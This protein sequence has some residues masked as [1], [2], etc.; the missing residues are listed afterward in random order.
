MKI[1]GFQKLSLIDYPGIIC[2]IVFTQGCLFRCPYCHNSELVDVKKEGV[3]SEDEVLDFLC[4]KKEFVEGVSITGG[5]PTLQKDLPEF[6]KKIKSLGF[7]V[8]LDTSG[9]Y[10]GMVQKLL[11]DNL[12]DY[13]A[14]DIKNTWE[15]YGEVVQSKN[16]TAVGNCKKTFL[17]IQSSGVDHEFRTTVFSQ[18]HTQDDFLEIAGYL[19][20]GEKY[21]IQNI[22]YTKTLDP[23]INKK[24]KLNVGAI[25]G[26]LQK[27][28]PNVIIQER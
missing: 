18:V 11:D 24:A 5:E 22:R 2:S 16:V 8:K 17:I 26:D 6:I 19:K 13:I 15:R 27:M 9:V 12:L 3:I 4:S 14:M 25:V 20:D 23:K 28:Y 10:P 1:A 7:L 21:F